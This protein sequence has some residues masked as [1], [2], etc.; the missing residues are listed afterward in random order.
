[1]NYKTRQLLT[2]WF[3]LSVIALA[4]CLYMISKG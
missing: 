3:A 4:P 1:M 2:I